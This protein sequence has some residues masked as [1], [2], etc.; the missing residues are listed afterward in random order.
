MQRHLDRS[1]ALYPYQ[2]DGDADGA[3]QG[4]QKYRIMSND[5]NIVAA[6][7]KKKIDDPTLDACADIDHKPQGSQ[8]YRVMSTDLA[9]LIAN[10]KKIDSDLAGDCPR[11][12]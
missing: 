9:I 5:L 12:E 1:V 11:P 10:W 7:W 6:N 2:C 8:D 4:I 3:T